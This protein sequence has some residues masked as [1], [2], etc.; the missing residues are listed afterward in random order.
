MAVRIHGTFGS[1]VLPQGASVLG[2][3]STCDVRIDDPRLSRT[4]ARFMVSGHTLRVEELGSRNGVLVDGQRIKGTAEL[5]HGQVVVCGPVVLMV[6]I[7]ETQPHPRAPQGGQDPATRRTSGRG[8]TEAMLAAVTVPE[9]P[10]SGGRGIDPAIFAAVSSGSGEFGADPTRASALQPAPMPGSITSP[11]EAVRPQPHAPRP[12]TRRSPSTASLEAAAFAP[13]ASGALEMP[14]PTRPAATDRLSAGL[15]DG[16]AAVGSA[17]IGLFIAVLVLAMAL[18]SAGA[19]ISDG[20][21][22]IGGGSSAGFP[23][24]LGAILNIHGLSAGLAAAPLA[25][26]ASPAAGLL[27]V[28]GAALAAMAMVAGPLLVLVVPTV[29]R[30]APAMHRRCGLAVVRTADGAAPGYAQ[31][32]LRW[33]LAGLLW[34]L[35]IPMVLMQRRSLHDSLSGCTVRQIR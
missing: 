5:H 32:L 10:G 11:L 18:A 17:G 13:S 30:G 27:L 12:P 23:A 2:R 31:A 3:G 20:V 25:A 33:L 24:I 9:P 22:R 8:D 1:W 26:S 16:A 28:L 34:P 6:S 21:P 35:A 15:L 19:G 7:D 4:H 14:T 29:L